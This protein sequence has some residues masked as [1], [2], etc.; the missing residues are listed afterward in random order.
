MT[1]TMLIG[2]VRVSSTDQNL[3]LQ[4]DALTAAGC[5]RI[6]TDTISG[7]KVSRPGVDKALEHL[8]DGD[9]LLVWKLDRL[10]RSVKNLT[11]FTDQ[12]EHA[13]VGFRSLTDQIDTTTPA[14]RFF[15]HVMA[16]LAQMER[17]LTIERTKAG[18]AAARAPGKTLRA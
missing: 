5:L 1:S 14:G 18:L 16:S 8:R 12:L 11:A 2:Y 9:T 17:E 13:G 15:F 3:T 10:G 4:H 6:Y 7:A